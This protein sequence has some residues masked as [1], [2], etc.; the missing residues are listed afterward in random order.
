M[1]SPHV[2]PWGCVPSGWP[3]AASMKEVGPGARGGDP[4]LPGVAVA[5]AGR[6]HPPRLQGELVTPQPPQSSL[7]L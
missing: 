5:V 1:Y 2:Y 6:R 7:T 3:L 4:H